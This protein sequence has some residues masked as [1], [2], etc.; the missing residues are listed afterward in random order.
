M[1]CEENNATASQYFVG[2][3]LRRAQG[4]QQRRL[5]LGQRVRA[6][7]APQAALQPAEQRAR[8]VHAPGVVPQQEGHGSQVAQPRHALVERPRARRAPLQRPAATFA[9]RRQ[10]CS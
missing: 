4:A 3:V 1:S 8:L 6:G 10:R 9:L 2:V 5:R 7:Q